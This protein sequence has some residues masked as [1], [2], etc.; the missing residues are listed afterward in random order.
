M[1]GVLISPFSRQLSC[2]A[3]VTVI[4]LDGLY[5]YLCLNSNGVSHLS[6]TGLESSFGLL[7][8]LL[9]QLE[10]TNMPRKNRNSSHLV[11]RSPA[12]TVW[13]GSSEKWLAKFSTTPDC[14]LLRKGLEMPGTLGTVILSSF[15]NPANATANSLH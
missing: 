11:F 3:T 1:S 2:S 10:Q 12:E 14:K 6:Q 7:N 15:R 5:N 9:L 8:R 13:F 4:Y